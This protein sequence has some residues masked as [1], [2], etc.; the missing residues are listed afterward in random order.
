ML[1]IVVYRIRQGT[2]LPI[3]TIRYIFYHYHFN[4]SGKVQFD[5]CK[6]RVKIIILFIKYAGLR[7]ELFATTML[8]LAL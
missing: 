5:V 1:F 4:I 6:L 2:E 7:C 3:I 8:P